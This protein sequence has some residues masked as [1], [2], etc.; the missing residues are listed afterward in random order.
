MNRLKSRKAIFHIFLGQLHIRGNSNAYTTLD[1]F[2]EMSLSLS[3]III[4]SWQLFYKYIQKLNSLSHP[5]GCLKV[6]LRPKNLITI[7]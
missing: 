4:I 1:R 5:L 3:A 2:T 7:Y 6:I